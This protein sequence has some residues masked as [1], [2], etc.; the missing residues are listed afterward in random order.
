MSAVSPEIL[1]IIKELQALPS[2]A[3]FAL[4]GGTNLALQYS[5]RISD[6]IDLFSPDII[7]KVGF[8][9]IEK[10]VKELYGDRAE[11]FD[12]PCDID[13]QFS[14]LRFF[15]RTDTG[16]VIK[17]E[18]LQNMKNLYDIEISDGVRILSKKDIGIFKLI[19][20]ANRSSQK[21]IYDLDFIT[22]EISLV[23]LYIALETKTA[24]YNKPEDRT[25]FDLD[26]HATPLD[27]PELLL[28]FDSVPGSAKLPAHTHDRI[29]IVEGNKSWMVSKIDW[30][31][32]MRAL[33]HYLG[34]EF[35]GPK[36]VD[37]S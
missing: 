8:A 18:V 12:D 34:K 15:V 36:G 31:T 23:D 35:P 22:N 17:V 24:Q 28:K 6:D 2:L 13:D 26:E 20:A 33:Y 9:K 10:E 29:Q 4:G 16:N 27:N 19:S 25:I 7:G 3:G 37:I 1:T 32:K 21:D 11:R 5:H 14:F 30:R